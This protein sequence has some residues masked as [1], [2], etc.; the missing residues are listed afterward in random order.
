MPEVTDDR[1]IG[2]AAAEQRLL[3]W[4]RRFAG[5]LQQADRPGAFG[6]ASAQGLGDDESGQRNLR[7]TRQVTA[8]AERAPGSPRLTGAVP[9]TAPGGNHLDSPDHLHYWVVDQSRHSE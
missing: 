5:A 9:P 7:R 2:E 4:R 6:A 3:L 8:M 1:V